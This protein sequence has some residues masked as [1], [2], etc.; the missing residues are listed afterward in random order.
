MTYVTIADVRSAIG[1]SDTIDDLSINLAIS[2]AEDLIDGYCGR[3]FGT[4]GTVATAR[5]YSSTVP[6]LV[7]IDDATAITLVE[8]DPGLD[9][10]WQDD[11]TSSDW[12]AEP[13]NGLNNG[14]SWPY[15]RL[16]AVGDYLYPPS[17]KAA[18]RV[19][20]T[21]GWPA[22]PDAVKQ[23][24]IQTTIRLF[25]R[26]DTPLGYGGGPD[27]GLLYVSR[28]LDGDVALLLAPYRRGPAI[29]GGIA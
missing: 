20:G 19:T 26:L 15:T 18:V 21:W 12:Q 4:A 14:L 3:S 5:V 13:L 16:R 27:T 10:S 8:T 28:Q 17:N 9:G 6:D 11:W 22:V 29:V 25:K 24:T 2:A 1:L 7:A 23:A